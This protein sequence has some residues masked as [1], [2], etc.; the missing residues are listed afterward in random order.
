VAVNYF[1]WGRR[2]C[3]SCQKPLLLRGSKQHRE[4]IDVR[5]VTKGLIADDGLV[6]G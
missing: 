6:A 4:N 3:P 5:D 1:M 2:P